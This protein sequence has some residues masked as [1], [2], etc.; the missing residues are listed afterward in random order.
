MEVRKFIDLAVRAS[1]DIRNIS[2]SYLYKRY[3]IDTMNSL[4][5]DN[6]AALSKYN[7]ILREELGV[8]FYLEIINFNYDPTDI[9]A[10]LRIRKCSTD[11]N[12]H[13]LI[14]Y[15][16][17]DSILSNSN[18]SSTNLRQS[19]GNIFSKIINSMRR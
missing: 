11:A 13:G 10:G 3:D 5:R 15:P 4:M 6:C 9:H 8:E 1:N 18:S 19:E 2:A 7:K 17:V 12:I 14:H 16:E